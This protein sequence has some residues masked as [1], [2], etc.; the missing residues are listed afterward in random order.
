M[1]LILTAEHFARIG[2]FL[3]ARIDPLL[4]PTTGSKH[5][6]ADDDT[7]RALRALH[8]TVQYHVAAATLISEYDTEDKQGQETTRGMVWAAWR[9]L[10]P[11]AR[12]WEDHPDYLP[13]F[14]K[15]PYSLKARQ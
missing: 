1:D 2:A 8:T 7:S 15:E 5:G 4:D 12:Q 3:N 13:E 10:S 14:G 9:T 6:F 11:I